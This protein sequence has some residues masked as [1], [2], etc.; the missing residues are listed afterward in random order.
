MK[1]ITY[2]L[3]DCLALAKFNEIKNNRW[4]KPLGGLWSS[5][6]NS[7]WG[8]KDWCNQQ[9]WGDLNSSFTFEISGNILCIDNLDDLKKLTWDKDKYGYTVIDFE[10]ICEKYD[11]IWL[12]EKGERETRWSD[13]SLYGWDCETVLILNKN[14]IKEIK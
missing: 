3:G 9:D 11:A 14:C 1:L 7:E 13:P 2:G 4:V 8:W 10:E 5:P 12:T 6:I